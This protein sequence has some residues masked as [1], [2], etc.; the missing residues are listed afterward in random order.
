MRLLVRLVLSGP[1]LTFALGLLVGAG[2]PT[3]SS[4]APAF[5][6]KEYSRTT[7]PP[8]AFTESFQA[9]R[10]ERAFRLRLE[11]GPGGQTRVSS[12]SVSV[13]GTTVVTENDFSQQVALIERPV[14]LAAQNTM[15]VTLAGIPLGTIALAIVSDTGCLEVALT[16][17]A[18]GA[19]VAAGLILARGTVRG[20]PDVGVTI[21][22]FPAAV[23]EEAFVA[24][25][26]LRPEDTGLVA[27]ATA[28]DGATA[29][30]RL[31]LT[32]LSGPEPDLLLSPRPSS[33]IASLSVDFSVATL[34]PVT[35][36][37]LDFDGDGAVD[38]RGPTLDGQSFVYSVPGL[39]LPTV[40]L[41]DPQGHTRT[42]TT[43]LQVY[44]RA[45]FDSL[46]QARWRSMKDA[47]RRGDMDGALSA[48]AAPVRERYREMFA[49]LMVSFGQIDLVLTDVSFVRLDGNQAEYQM[50]RIDGGTTLSY[51]VLFVKDVDGIWRLKFF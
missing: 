33:G 39:Y 27:V 14:A 32:V 44:D 8:N 31:P 1:G 25:I 22:G 43:V 41:T 42:A 19:S 35:E 17:P 45:V 40:T 16:S 50:L 23:H 28:G 34:A 13:N 51:L 11:N 21:N 4:G 46:V 37:A 9:C 36:M 7:G 29:E 30:A 6:P 2:L 10:P 38:F 5:G 20:G 49:G 15:T 48:I 26:P 12:G 47:L 24:L 3:S 18:P